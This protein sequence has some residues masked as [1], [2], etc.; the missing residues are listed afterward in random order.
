MTSS[1]HVRFPDLGDLAIIWRRN[2]GSQRCWNLLDISIRRE[3]TLE[4]TRRFHVTSRPAAVDYIRRALGKRVVL[5]GWDRLGARTPLEFYP[6]C[7][8]E[9]W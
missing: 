3:D 9:S 4:C 8:L 2:M 6:Q 5:I 1:S 7:E